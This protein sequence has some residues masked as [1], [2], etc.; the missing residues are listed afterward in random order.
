VSAGAF[1]PTWFRERELATTMAIMLNRT[2]LTVDLFA[3][4]PVSPPPAE[5]RAVRQ[6]HAR[7]TELGLT[8]PAFPKTT[9]QF[10]RAPEGTPQGAETRKRDDVIEMVFVA[11]Q[12]LDGLRRLALHELCHVHQFATDAWLSSE[13]RETQAEMFAWNAMQGWRW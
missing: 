7:A 13:E 12:P 4:P 8:L 3:C 9:V 2:P 1:D 5:L 11:G 6:A 10:V